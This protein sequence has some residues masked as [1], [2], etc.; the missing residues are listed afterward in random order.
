MTRKVEK[1]LRIQQVSQDTQ[2]EELLQNPFNANEKRFNLINPMYDLAVN[3]MNV[4]KTCFSVHSYIT[5]SEDGKGS[6]ENKII[7]YFIPFNV[8]FIYGCFIYFLTV[9]KFLNNFPTFS[10]RV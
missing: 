5:F 8:C 3:Q 1:K 10:S 9:L 6:S 4:I 2:V 7:C